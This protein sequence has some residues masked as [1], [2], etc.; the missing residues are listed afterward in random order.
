VAVKD[1]TL[2][3]NHIMECIDR[4]NK[5]A[6]SGHE[7]FLKNT[8]IQDAVYRNLEVIGEAARNL[9]ENTRAK[10]PDVPWKKVIGLR[11]VLIHAYDGVDPSEVWLVIEKELPKL[12]NEIQT[13]L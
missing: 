4:I 1:Q 2:Y 11:N 6:Q 12:K 10:M 13:H 5:Y 8:M 7:D 3:L 9:N